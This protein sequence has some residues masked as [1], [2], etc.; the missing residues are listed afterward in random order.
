[1]LISCHR[2]NC[3][4]VLQNANELC[5]KYLKVRTVLLIFLQFNKKKLNAEV[6]GP[7]QNIFHSIVL[8]FNIAH[9]NIG[10]R[11]TIKPQDNR[12]KHQRVQLDVLHLTNATVYSSIVI[13]QI[14]EQLRLGLIRLE[15]QASN[16]SKV[17]KL[18]ILVDQLQVH[19]K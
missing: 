9:Q 16:I 19:G 17:F 11:F 5:I 2:N 15:K 1:M 8:F 12:L 18:L 6:A 13:S 4:Q 3:W 14:I 7:G 10:S